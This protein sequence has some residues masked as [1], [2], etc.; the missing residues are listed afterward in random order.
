MT[1]WAHEPYAGTPPLPSGPAD[2][3]AAIS[4]PAAEEFNYRQPFELD[5]GRAAIIAEALREYGYQGCTADTVTEELARPDS[6]RTDVGRFAADA[7][8]RAGWRP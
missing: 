6:E 4:R 5:L 7:L 1:A 3:H 8:A 2:R